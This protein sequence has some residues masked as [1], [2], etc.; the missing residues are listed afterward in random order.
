MKENYST[1]ILPEITKIPTNSAQQLSKWLLEGG[2]LVR[3]AGEAL[4]GEKS[5]FLT[6]QA[7]F[8]RT[9]Y[10]DGQ[11]TINNKLFINAFEKDSIFYGIEVPEDIN[12]KK[13]LIFDSSSNQPKVLA[14]LSDNTP[15]VSI[16]KF[17]EGE[18]IL[19]HVGA[20]NDWSNLPM[21]SLFP[22]MLNRILLLSKNYKSSN[23][24]NLNLNKE[25]NGF[26]NL[27]SPKKVIAVDSYDKLK[28]IKPSLN[29]PL[30]QYENSEI[31]ITLNLA[32][33]LAH[34]DIKKVF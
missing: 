7:T 10:I 18:I 33:N 22:D 12:I 2:T 6:Y 24:K 4:A 27:T 11:L 25:I 30:G 13:Q 32:T 14:K 1:I 5:D 9:R 31:S 3:F 34:N 29:T 26:G 28:T 19:F 20:N 17:G 16:K 15:L 23:I 21:S 8:G